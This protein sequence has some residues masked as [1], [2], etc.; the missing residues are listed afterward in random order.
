MTGPR[1][2]LVDVD[3]ATDCFLTETLGS[4]R[5]I[6]VAKSH[7]DM[8]KF[9]IAD[10]NYQNSRSLLTKIYLKIHDSDRTKKQGTWLTS[11]TREKLLDSLM[12]AQI[13]DRRLT[14]ADAHEK[15]CK[16]LL[17]SPEY[18][19]WL[20][21]NKSAK[22]SSHGLLWI[23][24]NPGAG[25]STI[26]KFA[27]DNFPTQYRTISFFFNAR[28]HKLERCTLGMYRSLVYQLME[29]LSTATIEI[30]L[31]E[32]GV[33]PQF[34]EAAE[35]LP[36]WK[37]PVLQRLFR[38]A[39]KEPCSR[40]VACFVDALDECPQDEIWQMLSFMESLT[41]TAA[42]ARVDLRIC[43]A[44]RH[45]P[46][47][48]IEKAIPLILD[49]QPGHQQDITRYIHGNLR[50]GTGTI[51][52]EVRHRLLKKSSNIFMWVVLVVAI[53][54]KAYIRGRDRDMIKMLEDL[55]ADL[56]RL[57]SD[58]VRSDHERASREE[59]RLCIQ[60]VLWSYRPLTPTELYHAIL[61]GVTHDDTEPFL[62]PDNLGGFI[63]D[64][65]KGLVEI[66]K[67]A[68]TSSRVNVQFI[69]E[70]VR[71]FFIRSR[72]FE[73]IP[74]DDGNGAISEAAIQKELS[75]YCLQYIQ[76]AVGV[77]NISSR[78]PSTEV[79]MDESRHPFLA[80]AIE[81]VLE[82]AEDA[83]KAGSNI[84]D[85]L[86]TVQQN[87]AQSVHFNHALSRL[88]SKRYLIQMQNPP[89]RLLYI[90]AKRNL[91][92]LIQRLEH[93]TAYFE[94]G[95]EIWRA[96]ILVALYYDC[97]WAV[98]SMLQILAV[99]HPPSSPLRDFQKC[100]PQFLQVDHPRR[101]SSSIYFQNVS[102]F[103]ALLN[104]SSPV[105]ALYFPDI[106]QPGVVDTT[107]VYGRTLLSLL[108]ERGLHVGVELLLAHEASIDT[109]DKEGN[110]PLNWASRQGHTPV[111][112]L[113]LDHG[114][115]VR[116]KNMYGCSSLSL[117]AA[118]R[119]LPTTLLLLQRG[120][121]I[122]SPDG[123]GRT[124]LARAAANGYFDLVNIL[125]QNG[126]TLD[127]RDN[128]NRTPL[129]HAA[130]NG[131]ADIV[132]FLLEQGPDVDLQDQN[133]RTPLW[134]AAVNG[135]KGIVSLL[136]ARGARPDIPD[137][138]GATPWWLANFAG[139]KDIAD[140]IRAY[141]TRMQG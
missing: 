31:H 114:A 27:V 128:T 122:D 38:G 47:I 75:M 21:T 93:Q 101:P 105:V 13:D 104:L 72:G 137:A 127:A 78:A 91:A 45:Y 42:A 39:T 50:I 85:L 71:D 113:L 73:E 64:T 138:L 116:W 126:A 22:S 52:G 120:A 24:G 97:F 17:E 44:S 107:N 139:R 110:T 135:Y 53:L 100:Y 134:W 28:G 103:A 66:T 25:K 48:R 33:K 118:G 111:V 121:D 35:F 26:M 23:R 124:P 43:F 84:D 6:A 76:N 70:S 62:C 99:G 14:I 132:Q 109:A 51:T 41:A 11:E 92:Y 15:T 10:V 129:S 59:F 141:T 88:V 5:R 102:I 37:E 82:H 60:W 81:H 136:L 12:F 79:K 130:S 133:G 98:K 96:P 32:A 77:L 3:S 68:A 117:A 131:N 112:D 29:K 83:A 123:L 20:G 36:D 54:N 16:W 67:R 86:V 57:F 1:D 18:R 46:I 74:V 89:V 125:F 106:S 30:I 94:E 55:P 61:L 49:S 9:E 87:L 56:H 95:P 2:C 90:L 7:S 34:L 8:V 140:I 108:A 115:D 19:S 69:H 119:H 80:Y 65:S 4:S 63:T 40:S 58:V